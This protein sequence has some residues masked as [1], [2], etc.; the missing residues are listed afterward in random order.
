MCLLQQM[1]CLGFL[2]DRGLRGDDEDGTVPAEARMEPRAGIYELSPSCCGQ[3]FLPFPFLSSFLALLPFFLFNNPGCIVPL[4]Q[5]ICVPALI[6][7][8][9]GGED[10]S[11][12]GPGPCPASAGGPGR[13]EGPLGVAHL[14]GPFGPAAACAQRRGLRQG[15]HGL[16]GHLPAGEELQ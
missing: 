1:V 14:Q 4:N 10:R 13:R 11:P 6:S 16:G 3:A 5:T 15:H 12:L 9:K 2:R 8:N 7:S